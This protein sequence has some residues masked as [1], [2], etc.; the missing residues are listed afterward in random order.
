MSHD[1]RSKLIRDLNE[2]T[3]T[4]RAF[5]ARAA[6]VGMAAPAISG[7]IAA[8]GGND[9]GSDSKTVN[10]VSYGGSYNENLQKSMLDGFERDTGIGV[11]LGVNTSL[12]PVK[13]QV[14]SGNV[15]WDI[16]EL[17][18]AEYEVAVKQDLLEP[19]DYNII[20]TSNV[21]DY[22]VKKFGIKY[23]LFLFVIAWDQT[24]IPARRAP[25][26][27]TDFWET[28]S[29]PGKRSLYDKIDS[30]G[31]LEA[32]LV[33]DGVALDQVFP[34][35]VERALSS[36][37][38]L[39]RDNIVFHAA[40]EESIQ[41]LSSHELPLATS[42]NGRVGIAR[43]DEGAKIGF[44]PEQAVLLGDYLVVPKGAPNPEQAFRLIDYIVNNSRA[45]AAY[46]KRTYYAIANKSALKLLPSELAD[47]LPTSPSLEG[48][49]LVKD[50]T[51]WADNLESVTERF[52][53][54]QLEG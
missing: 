14:T 32:A 35:D 18:G 37:D 4:R 13:V 5:A 46:A 20:K 40:P 29:L 30:A 27:W 47:Q 25:S 34:L 44:T 54:W 24:K 43:R 19:F 1:E 42:W 38:R 53:Q 9:S 49:I 7:F 51:W 3:I 52:K 12:A 39:G 45:G 50:D 15:R 11:K 10:F 23:A 33:A 22:A 26:T 6:A 8:C 48:R 16:A 31:L 36:L 28:S 17:T 21:P 41:Q 2:G